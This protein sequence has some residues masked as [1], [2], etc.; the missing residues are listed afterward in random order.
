MTT[1]TTYRQPPPPRPS[2]SL[3][4]TP[5]KTH[6]RKHARAHPIPEK[7]LGTNH[8]GRTAESRRLLVSR[9]SS[10]GARRNARA[11]SCSLSLSPF[12]YRRTFLA[13]SL[14]SFA[15]ARSF[16]RSVSVYLTRTTTTRDRH[17]GPSATADGSVVSRRHR[18]AA[19]SRARRRRHPRPLANQ[20]FGR[21]GAHVA[22]AKP[23]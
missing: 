16:A 6:G 2:L 22:P 23:R 13:I 10:H 11:S 12:V 4:H 19:P 3:V 18:L 20:Q 17:R 8:D 14:P 7:L 15:L 21:A 1:T 5:T 9:G